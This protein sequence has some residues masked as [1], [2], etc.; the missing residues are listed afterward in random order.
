MKYLI[1]AFV[2]I[3][4]FVAIA[5][6]QPLTTSSPVQTVTE[7]PDPKEDPR[8]VSKKTPVAVPRLTAPP[9]IDGVLSD[10]VWQSAAVFGDFVQ[11][12]P[13]DNIA[14]T[15]PTEFLMA[16]DA[17]NLYIAFRVKQDR[18]QIRATVARRDNIF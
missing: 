5:F 12:N 2:I 13:G 16:Y 15:H 18:N 6:G 8:Y 10:E 11:I 17:R 14:P 4:A 7:K 3:F 1:K 9:V